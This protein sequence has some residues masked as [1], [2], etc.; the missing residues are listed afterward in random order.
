MVFRLVEL[1]APMST[2]FDKPN[3]I[4]RR[5]WQKFAVCVSHRAVN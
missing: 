2:T 5:E 3:R 1:N 4:T